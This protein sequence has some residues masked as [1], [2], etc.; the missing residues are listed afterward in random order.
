MM[1]RASTNQ[2]R[3]PMPPFSSESTARECVVDFAA[4]KVFVFTARLGQRRTAR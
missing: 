1:L 2:I 3:H 4:Q